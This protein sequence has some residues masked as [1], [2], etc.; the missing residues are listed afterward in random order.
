MK[1][2][3]FITFLIL[4]SSL[5]A[6]TYIGIPW[7]EG[8][9]IK[10]GQEINGMIRLGG[11]LNAPW[12]NSTKVYFVTKDVYDTAKRIK[13]K[14]IKEYLPEDLEGYLTYTTDTN[15]KRVEMNFF[16]HE[17][18]IMG[19]LRKKKGKAFLRLFEKGEVNVYSYTPEPAKKIVTTTRERREDVAYAKNQSQLFLKKSNDKLISAVDADLIQILS[20]CPEVVE[21]IENESYGFQPKNK[22]PKRKGLGKFISNAIGD[23]GLEA[24]ILKAVIDYNNCVE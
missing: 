2:T 1:C 5:F 10:D 6:Q 22:R 20:G 14:M 7:R 17:I 8:T 21:K 4:S 18:M 19:A 16:T 11:D 13:K 9:I 15:D 12:L 3:L 24:G 23:N